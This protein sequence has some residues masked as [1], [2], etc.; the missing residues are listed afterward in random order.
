MYQVITKTCSTC[1][2][3]K[4]IEDFVLD[5]RRRDGRTGQCK[6]CRS[7]R[8]K[9]WYVANKLHCSE[10]AKEYRKKY[11]DRLNKNRS[12]YYSAHKEQEHLYY[13]HKMEEFTKKAALF[14][15][16]VCKRCGLRTDWYEVYDFHHRNKGEKEHQI[17]WMR[18]KDWDSE[19]VPELKKCDLLCANCHALLTQVDARSRPDRTRAQIYS[20]A[21]IDRHK[22]RCVDYLGKS[23]QICGTTVADLS[24]YHFHHVDPTTKLYKV[25]SL[26]GRDW[27]TVVKPE[28][29]KC[30]LLCGNCHRAVHYSR[31]PDL[32]LIPG[33]KE[34]RVDL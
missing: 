9:E 16:G 34:D 26:I 3:K 14:L 4:D 10:R 29:D 19:V 2:Q 21:R 27:D 30:A 11:R 20:D 28:L 15:G 22:T 5:K 1:F 7:N 6:Q 33:V 24:I 17:S 13:R 23:C 12:D 18:C 25:S 8:G 32:I 31:Y